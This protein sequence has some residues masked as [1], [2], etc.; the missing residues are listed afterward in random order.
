[1]SAALIEFCDVGVA[2]GDQLVLGVIAIGLIANSA[3]S[4]LEGR[5]QRGHGRLSER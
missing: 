2:Y 4:G 5:A 3:L 1:M